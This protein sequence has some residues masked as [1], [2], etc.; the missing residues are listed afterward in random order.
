[1][2]LFLSSPVNPTPPYPVVDGCKLDQ[3]C[4]LQV[5]RE[6]I[7]TCSLLGIRPE[8]KL[9]WRT[10]HNGDSNLISFSNTQ[11]KVTSKGN[12]MDVVITSNYK[13]NTNDIS[14][15]TLVCDAAKPNIHFPQLSTKLELLFLD[16]MLM[17]FLHIIDIF[18]VIFLTRL[19]I[20]V[21]HSLSH[22]LLKTSLKSI[23]N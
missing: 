5:Y 18:A 1:M 8:A 22:S 23:F 15:L 11:T 4:V 20:P 14:R 21:I 13:V 9:F 6:G 12:T 16:S 3:F 7:L 17:L 2:I 10:F 19:I